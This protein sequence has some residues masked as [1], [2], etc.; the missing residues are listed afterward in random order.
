MM[1]VSESA[2]AKTQIVSQ[3]YRQSAD[4]VSTVVF[5]AATIESNPKSAVKHK[6]ASERRFGALTLRSDLRSLFPVDRSVL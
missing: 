3:K 1:E 2:K 4:R 6:R 5:I